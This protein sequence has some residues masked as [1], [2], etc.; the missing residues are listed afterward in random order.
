MTFEQHIGRIVQSYMGMECN[1]FTLNSMADDVRQLVIAAGKSKMLV[2]VRG[3]TQEAIRKAKR[4]GKPSP[5]LDMYIGLIDEHC[6][7]WVKEPDTI[8]RGNS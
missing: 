5:P 6:P 4:K 8:I 3:P 7:D 1:N 2:A